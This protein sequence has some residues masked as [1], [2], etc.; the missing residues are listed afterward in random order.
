MKHMKPL[1]T[2]LLLLTLNLVSPLSLSISRRKLILASG[3]LLPK[4][5]LTPPCLADDAITADVT[6][7]AATE[8][9]TDATNDSTAYSN[10][11]SNNEP[12]YTLTP[13]NTPTNTP[14]NTQ[15]SPSQPTIS[16]D[17]FLT[18]LS[19]SPSSIRLVTLSTPTLTTIKCT[20][21]DGTSFDVSGAVES[22]TDPRSPLKVVS[23]CRDMGVPFE[24]SLLNKPNS[25]FPNVNNS[26]GKVYYNSRVKEA[27]AKNKE[28]R[29]R[30][31]RDEEDR[32]RQ[33]N[34]IRGNF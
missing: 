29:D 23:K 32:V 15:A 22:N 13:T 12:N 7:D 21:K 2:T 20:L 28:K 1:S 8:A 4:T 10:T 3:F 24:T 5:P 11:N 30:V 18:L 34:I 14:I 17:A 25:E 6:T 19:T 27:A 16:Y 9:T 31:K 33:E 26:H